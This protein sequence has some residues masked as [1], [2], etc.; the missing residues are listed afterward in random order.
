GSKTT[1]AIESEEG[2]IGYVVLGVHDSKNGKDFYR[3]DGISSVTYADTGDDDFDPKT[4]FEEQF[5]Y[6]VED[7]DGGSD[8]ATL[9]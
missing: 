4:S 8:T 2:D 3:F 1:A 7:G 5:A 6:T 9:T